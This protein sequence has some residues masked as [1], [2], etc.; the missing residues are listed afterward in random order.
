MKRTDKPLRQG[1]HLCFRYV[2]QQENKLITADAGKKVAGT[3]RPLDA[4]DRLA[5]KI[6]AGLM[7]K[8]IVDPFEFVKIQITKSKR[9]LTRDQL[10]NMPLEIAAV[11]D[12]RKRI[13]VGKLTELLFIPFPLADV[14]TRSQ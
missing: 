7:G 12:A 1:G 11:G 5:Q 8:M 14:F 10:M 2:R 9:R 13:E 3:Q 6:I 4:L